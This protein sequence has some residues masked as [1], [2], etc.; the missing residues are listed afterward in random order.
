[1]GNRKDYPE[2]PKP[3]YRSSSKEPIDLKVLNAYNNPYQTVS[4][5]YNHTE[6]GKELRIGEW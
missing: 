2:I 6:E 5:H 4:D 3:S 1:M